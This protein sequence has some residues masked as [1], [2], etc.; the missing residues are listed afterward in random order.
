MQ[1]KVIP[2]DVSIL[3]VN[4]IYYEFRLNG[5]LMGVFGTRSP[6]RPNP[7]G[8]SVAAIGNVCGREIELFGVDIVDGYVH[9]CI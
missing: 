4:T 8:L 7:I 3:V 1:Y 2:T 5:G 9:I 6:H